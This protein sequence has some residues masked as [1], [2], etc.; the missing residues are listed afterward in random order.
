M[1]NVLLTAKE[2][3]GE[4]RLSATI[5]PHIVIICVVCVHSLLRYYC[6]PN[7][8]ETLVTGG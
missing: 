2:N 7:F 8:L 4:F 1:G 3:Q 6:L 5:I